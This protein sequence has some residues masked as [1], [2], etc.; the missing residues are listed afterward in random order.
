[1]YFNLKFKK[2]FAVDEDAIKY[3]EN[4]SFLIFIDAINVSCGYVA[5]LS[6]LVWDKLEG[7][8]RN[9]ACFTREIDFETNQNGFKS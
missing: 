9:A 3:N 8:T 4:E 1:M 7:G 5:Y 6:L 2:R